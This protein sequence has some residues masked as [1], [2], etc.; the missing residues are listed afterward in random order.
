MIESILKGFEV[1]TDAQGV[2][3]KGRVKNIDNISLEG[4]ARLRELILDLA[5]R[6]KLV[7]Q[8]SDEESSTR[9][10]ESFFNY[11]AE[12]T[13]EGKKKKGQQSSIVPESEYP[14]ILPSGW[15]IEYLQNLSLLITKG[16]TPTSYGHPFTESGVKF[17]KV[18]NIEKNRITHNG[19]LQYISEDTHNFLE[20]SKLELGDILFS[21][22]G[23]IGRTGIVVE[24]DL[25]ANTNQA[26][27]I[28]R[29]TAKVFDPRFLII[30]L[31]SFVSNVI[32]N[33]ARGG[34]MYNVSLGD[35]SELALVIP[36]I[37]EQKR[38]VKKVDELMSICDKLEEHQTANLT[39]HHH[40]VKSLLEK[41]TNAADAD[42][43]EAAWEKLSEHFDTL[44]CT[45]DSIEQLKQTILQLAIMG[46]LVKQ[47]PNDEP[48]IELQNKIKTDFEEMAKEGKAKKPSVV[49]SI[50]NEEEP[51]NLPNG[52]YWVRLQEIIQIS[53][54]D[55]LTASQMN[56]EGNIPVFGGNGINGYHD[57]SNISKPTIV[58][59][60]VGFYCGSI[61]I[62]P[63]TAWVTDNAFITT[64]S[65]DNMNLK[66]LY[67]LLKGTNLKENDNAT[68]QP[69]ISGRKVY[70]IIV[71][72]PPLNEQSRIV[73]KI[74][75]LYSLCETLY[76]KIEKAAEVKSLLSQTVV[77]NVSQ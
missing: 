68:A 21:I 10:V 56:S 62:T 44:F 51:F 1:W 41:L 48:A 37:A 29:G 57:K 58:I 70:P 31:D 18:E 66:F 74:E 72:L 9:L 16:A 77:A 43:L 24:E 36:P 4:I 47:E 7:N 55:G 42:E 5:I 19:K 13:Q 39:T 3:S 54:G 49:Q 45:E 65:E 52:W 50:T 20:R 2:K 59:G 75:E 30:Q 28:I 69:V 60:R 63:E 46:R 64:F 17:I 71:A 11:K 15:S 26:L 6:G 53:S 61:H 12:L 34:A 23:T 25:P 27:A 67:W 38:I 40:L 8:N 22:A 35:L 33:R 14:F 76:T 73:S 32:K